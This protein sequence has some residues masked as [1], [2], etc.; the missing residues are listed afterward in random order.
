MSLIKYVWIWFWL[1]CAV[2][3]S[4]T[5]AQELN[6]TVNVDAS[7]VSGGDRSVYSNLQDVVGRYMNLN[8]FTQDRFEAQ[9]RVKIFMQITIRSRNEPDNFVALMNLRVLRPVYGSTYESVLLNVLDEKFNFSFTAFQDLQFTD[10]TY[11]DE[12]TSMLNFYAYLALAADYDSFSPSG[13][14]PY[15]QHALDIALL[16]ST[17][18]QP[19]PGWSQE[20][21]NAQNRMAVANTMMNPN[22][23]G[24]HSALYKYHRTGM[25]LFETKPDQARKGVM[26][27]LK[28]MKKV[29]TANASSRALYLFFNA[30]NQEL[31]SIFSKAFITDKTTFLQ[32]ITEL[33]PTNVNN[34]NKIMQ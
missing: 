8:K 6:C 15:Y 31:V 29:Q 9:E 32:L 21:I 28:D 12:L 10:G 27:A 25:D 26:E 4:Q 24:F 7:Q 14:Q 33:D 11:T 23:T 1:L 2:S 20:N 34:Y 3:V 5:R 19:G 18:P 30:K 22:S 13:G 17:A 16:A